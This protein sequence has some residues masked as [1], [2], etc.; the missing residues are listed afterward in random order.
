MVV[1]SRAG[2][3]GRTPKT[4]VALTPR[5]IRSGP[6]TGASPDRLGNRLARTLES[7]SDAFYT[8]DREWRF[9]YLN[10]EAE[11]LQ[12]RTRADLLGRVVWEAFPEAVGTA[13][14]TEF[15][16][17]M[18]TGK[19]VTFEAYY[20][21]LDLWVAVRAFPSEDGLAVHFLDIND[22]RRSEQALVSSEQR[23]RALFEGAGDAIFVADDLGLFV[24]VNVAASE[25]LGVPRVGLIG[26]KL[27]DFVLEDAYV[28]GSRDA[29][30]KTFQQAR[31]LRGE[32]RLRHASGA[33]IEADFSAVANVSP[34]LH[35][36]ILRDITEQN[37]MQR[38]AARHDRILDA[39]R[40]LAPGDDPEA[41]ARAICVEIVDKGEFPS[42]AI[43]GF[44]TEDRAMALAARMVD[45]RGVEALPP[46]SNC[47]MDTLESKAAKGP[48][49]DE[50]RDPGDDFARKAMASIGIH[51]LAFAPIESDGQL[52]GLLAAGS[53]ASRE[54]VT[55]RLP[56]SSSTRR[57]RRR[58]SGRS[59]RRRAERAVERTRIR[60]I[61]SSTAYTSVFQPIVDM[62]TG[63]VLGYEALT[64]F[65]DGTPPDQVFRAAADVGVGLELEAATIR[66]ALEASEPLPAHRFLDI[67][68]SPGLVLAGE[69]L[70]ASSTGHPAASSWRSPSTSASRTTGRCATRSH[71]LGTRSGSLSTTPGPGSRRCAT[72]SSCR[73]RT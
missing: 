61:I 70:G 55:L 44:G 16:R 26:R 39:L 42:A 49:V 4:D 72:S 9:T 32:T 22:R 19:T 6:G 34:G 18:K 58:C 3:R 37:R 12:Q 45:G 63:A 7:I 40:R 56:R 15:H 17:A 23:Y 46:L 67:N 65:T 51:A 30:W 1:R 50:L 2:V 10:A 43:Y 52:I 64:R 41:T 28:G 11:R 53:D 54:A 24:D 47:R 13:F 73:P 14:D 33:V 66:S 71:R 48:W 21:P 20:P 68:V 69:P 29:G 31:A 8:L 27:D 5:R 57:S 35:L 59:P 62:T 36:G 38:T 25:L 60:A